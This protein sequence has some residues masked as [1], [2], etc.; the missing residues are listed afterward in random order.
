MLGVG[1][2]YTKQ[3][4]IKT[5]KNKVYE[6]YFITFS[7]NK[8]YYYLF[9]EILNLENCNRHRSTQYY[10]IWVPNILVYTSTQIYYGIHSI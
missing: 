7:F 2:H 6:L 1:R 9:R 8:N 10:L 5:I 3:I 4:K